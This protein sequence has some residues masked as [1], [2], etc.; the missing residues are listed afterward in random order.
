MRQ[1]EEM[2]WFEVEGEDGLPRACHGIKRL[3]PEGSKEITEAQAKEISAAVRS[4]ESK[5]TSV[6][7]AAAAGVDL[8]PIQ[9]Q[10]TRIAQVVTGHAASLDQ[11]Q[12]KIEAVSNSVNSLIRDQK[13]LAG[14]AG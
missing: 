6:V 7:N 11:Q 9:D 13:S 10:I 3:M 2:A 5:P 8:Q 1:P 12:G 4:R 14:G